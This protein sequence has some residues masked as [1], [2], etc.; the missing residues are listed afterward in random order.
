MP[1]VLNT[2][3]NLVTYYLMPLAGVNKQV[4]GRKFVNSYLDKTKMIIYIHISSKMT[5]EGYK[6][7][8][9]YVS[10]VVIKDKIYCLYKIP[11]KYFK[12]LEFFIKGKYSL[13][14]KETKKLIYKGSSL[15]YNKSVGD[16]KVS[17]PILQALDK[18]KVLRYYMINHLNIKMTEET[19]ELID[20]PNKSWFIESQI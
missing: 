19:N 18:T 11:Q 5:S 16:F 14:N 17:S 15:P 9:C 3:E 7:A 20:I 12:D 13:M 10:D 2:N 4:F 6:K 8:S 1:Y